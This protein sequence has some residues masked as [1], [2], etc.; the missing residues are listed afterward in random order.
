MPSTDLGIFETCINK[1]PGHHI[2]IIFTK[3]SPIMQIAQDFELYI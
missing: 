2:A 3:G 1:T